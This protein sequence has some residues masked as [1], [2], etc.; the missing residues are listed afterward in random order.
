MFELS[1]FFL[2]P[3][4]DTEKGKIEHKISDVKVNTLNHLSYNFLCWANFSYNV[5]QHKPTKSRSIFKFSSLVLLDL[6]SCLE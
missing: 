1:N 6:L 5:R 2:F 3:F 4:S